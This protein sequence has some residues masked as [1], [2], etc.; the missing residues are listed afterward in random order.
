MVMNNNQEIAYAVIARKQLG[1][2]VKQIEKV[3]ASMLFKMDWTDEK[4]DASDFQMRPFWS[5]SCHIL[6]FQ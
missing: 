1:Y 6:F 4:K 3:Q 2:T 5:L